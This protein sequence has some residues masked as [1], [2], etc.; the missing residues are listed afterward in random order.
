MTLVGV[1]AI[2]VGLFAMH[3]LSAG[4]GHAPLAEAGTHAHHAAPLSSTPDTHGSAAVD[5]SCASDGCGPSHAM[6]WMT[7]ILALLVGSLLLVA[8]ARAWRP[9][10]ARG[11]PV[12]ALLS[13]LRVAPL[14]PPSLIMLS[15][16]RT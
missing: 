3:T 9:S 16:S 8:A 1:V 5:E 12:A 10:P 2:V 7:C 6:A 13:G 4:S 15:I 14:R 11:A